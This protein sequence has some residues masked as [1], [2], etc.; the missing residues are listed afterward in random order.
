VRGARR[1]AAEGAR[2]KIEELRNQARGDH[3]VAATCLLAALGNEHQETDPETARALTG[4]VMLAEAMHD[5]KLL[6]TMVQQALT[7]KV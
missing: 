4:A 1:G 7:K 2:G 3:G 6:R 5:L